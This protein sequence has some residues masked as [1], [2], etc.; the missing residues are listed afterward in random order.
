MAILRSPIINKLPTKR[1][2]AAHGVQTKYQN[3]KKKSSIRPLRGPAIV[4]SS[5]EDWL[6]PECRD[7]NAL[8]VRRHHTGYD[9]PTWQHQID[10]V[11]ESG[12]FGEEQAL[13][14]EIQI[15]LGLVSEEH[16]AAE[17]IKKARRIV[18]LA[19]GA[20]LPRELG[21]LIQEDFVRIG[22]TL[23]R[24]VPTA[25][26]KLKLD[27]MGENAC[28]RWH[29]DHYIGRAVVTY[30]LCGTDYIDSKHVDF[31]EL[32]NCGN[33]DCILL[34]PSQVQTA[35][36]G[37]ILFMKGT[38]FPSEPNGGVII[39]EMNRSFSWCDAIRKHEEGR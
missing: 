31:W 1:K 29:Q 4:C 5:V 25:K 8:Y 16:L 2:D 23:A 12:A 32:L 18:G 3:S 6:Q 26:M 22:M 7:Y 39:Q 20:G 28:H 35:S 17:L 38:T 27:I 14:E 24:L 21:L 30:N 36:V 10:K 13:D 37:D 15:S 11:A 9:L 19:T 33:K 34:D